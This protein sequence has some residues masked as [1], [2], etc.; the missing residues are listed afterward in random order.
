MRRP[1]SE[2]EVTLSEAALLVTDPEEFVAVQ[3]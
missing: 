1:G 3:V 2:V